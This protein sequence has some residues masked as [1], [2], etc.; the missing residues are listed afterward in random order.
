[1]KTTVITDMIRVD[2]FINVDVVPSPSRYTQKMQIG[3]HQIRKPSADPTTIQMA[4]IW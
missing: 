4:L 1:M 2:V 3:G